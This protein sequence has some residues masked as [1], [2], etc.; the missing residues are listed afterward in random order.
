MGQQSDRTKME[1]RAE[2]Y[3]SARLELQ[4]LIDNPEKHLSIDVYR[5]HLRR[6]RQDVALA[7]QAMMA[8][9]IGATDG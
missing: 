1:E 3:Q 8:A 7:H 9:A 6:A 4:R 2:D 5:A